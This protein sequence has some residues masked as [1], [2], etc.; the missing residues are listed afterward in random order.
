MSP[1][2][3]SLAKSL[4]LWA[5]ERDILITAQDIPGLSNT[6]ADIGERSIRLGAG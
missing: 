6:V 2:L 5:L 4:W 1:V 3:T